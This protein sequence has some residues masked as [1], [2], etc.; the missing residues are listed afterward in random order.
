LDVVSLPTRHPFLADCPTS[1]V[2]GPGED[3]PCQRCH[4]PISRSE[5]QYEFEAVGARVGLIRMHVPCYRAWQAEL[6]RARRASR[7]T[8]TTAPPCVR[9]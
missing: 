5:V 8:P 9:V 7:T 1:V 6:A 4:R 2:A 3:L